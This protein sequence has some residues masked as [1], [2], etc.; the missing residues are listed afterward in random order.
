[1]LYSKTDRLAGFSSPNLSFLLLI[2]C[3]ISVYIYIS[4]EEGHRLL[5]YVCPQRKYYTPYSKNCLSD[6]VRDKCKGYT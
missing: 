3:C 4:S 2:S 6:I 5:S 1:M